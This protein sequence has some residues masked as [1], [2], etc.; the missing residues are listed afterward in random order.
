MECATRATDIDYPIFQLKSGSCRLDTGWQAYR[1]IVQTASAQFG[2]ARESWSRSCALKDLMWLGGALG[3]GDFSIFDRSVSSGVLALDLALAFV[4][5]R[6]G[7]VGRWLRRVAAG[8]GWLIC[9]A[10]RTTPDKPSVDHDVIWAEL[11]SLQFDDRIERQPRPTSE[12]PWERN[13]T[14]RRDLGV[15]GG[16]GATRV[17]P[18]L[19]LTPRRLRR[20]V[21]SPAMRRGCHSSLGRRARC[22]GAARL[23]RPC[24]L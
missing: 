20:R 22:R 23:C 13:V 8:D 3:G 9:V 6:N 14:R 7:K 15:G 17:A 16:R 5:G 2:E 11:G 19:S 12:R 24:W 4:L 1:A 21:G 18:R 10:H